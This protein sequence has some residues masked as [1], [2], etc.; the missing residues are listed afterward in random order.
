MLWGLLILIL[1]LVVLLFINKSKSRES[2]ENQLDPAVQ[3][4]YTA[5]L[6]FYNPFCASWQKAIQ[7]SVASE[8]PQQPLT[9]PSQISTSSAPSI[10]EPEMNDYI[11]KLSQQLN[12]PLPQICI[13]LPTSAT[14]TQLPQILQQIPKDIQPYMNALQWMNTNLSSAH[15]N[16]N[17]ALN[18]E[19]FDN[20]CA[21]LAQCIANNP[22]IAQQ[23]AQ[24][25]EQ[26]QQQNIQQQGQQLLDII[27]PFIQSQPLKQAQQENQTLMQKSQDIQNQ[28]QSGEI[29]NQIS[30]P[31]EP[32]APPFVVP[33]GGQA[34]QQMKDTNPEKYNEYQKNYAPWFGLKQL[35]E[36]INATL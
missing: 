17:S 6:E 28:A 26:Q 14:P 23:I 36:Q 24:Q 20:E 13:P 3:Q 18:V 11:V 9:D 34:L 21:N 19:G 27:T 7:S 4:A 5:F 25:Q 12:H 10:S 32:Q 8:I 33:P 1:I 16:L 22:Q 31:N 2:F 29:L 30:L 15:A 35:M